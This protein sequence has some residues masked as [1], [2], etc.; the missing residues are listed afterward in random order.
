M[1]E[2]LVPISPAE[3]LDKIAI[4]EVKI[5]KIS[6]KEKL[7]NVKH[8]LNILKK[9]MKQHIKSSPEL[10][11]LFEKLKK[12]SFKGW[13]IED[14]KRSK[15]RDKNFDKEFIEFARGAFKNNDERSAI[16]KEINLLLKSDI[17]EE[18]SYEKY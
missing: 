10:A 15:E 11:R 8:E 6:D 14:G 5:K 9:T 13:D 4:L 18:K 3:L 7:K 12:L 16:K 1:N 2:I 17:I